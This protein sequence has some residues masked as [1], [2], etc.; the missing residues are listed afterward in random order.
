MKAIGV[1]ALAGTV[2]KLGPKNLTA[3]TLFISAVLLV[4]FGTTKSLPVFLAVILVIG[5]LGGGTR[6]TAA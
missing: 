2:R 1:L 4:I 6:K 5:F 3:V